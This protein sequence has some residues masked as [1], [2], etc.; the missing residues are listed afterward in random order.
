E[1]RLL[2]RIRSVYVAVQHQRGAAPRSKQRPADVGAP[3]LDLLPLHREPELA[4]RLGDER[5][6]RF[7]AAGEARDRDRT[8]RPLDEPVAFDGGHARKCGSTRSPKSR[9]CS[10][11]R[12]PQSSSMT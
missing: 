9:I 5:G 1:P 8:A 10:W 12:P 6:H 2:A 3:L 11:R 7:L 4:K